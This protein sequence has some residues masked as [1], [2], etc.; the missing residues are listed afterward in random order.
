MSITNVTLYNVNLLLF[1]FVRALVI[2]F[3][4]I[5][6]FYSNRSLPSLKA[7]VAC[8]FVVLGFMIGALSDTDTTS[9]WQGIAYGVI[10]ALVCA[11]YGFQVKRTLSEVLGDDTFK[12]L[13][14]NTI[15][16]LIL[17]VPFIWLFERSILLEELNRLCSS[18]EHLFFFIF[19]AVMGFMIS[20]SYVLNIRCSTPLTSHIVGNSKSALQSILV[21]FIPSFKPITSNRELNAI[22]MFGLFVVIVA[23]ISY[24]FIQYR[25]GRSKPK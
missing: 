23:S 4:I 16:G 9:T 6:T 10:S 2:P 8:S 3:S 25:A 14:Y 13:Y 21:L 19:T 18:R 5:I 15:W 22:N 11:F 20:I 17:L 24:S 12:T 1:Q 7:G